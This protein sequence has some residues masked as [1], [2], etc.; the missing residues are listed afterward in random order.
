MQIGQVIRDKDLTDS[1][2]GRKLL[3]SLVPPALNVAL[4]AGDNAS[5]VEYFEEKAYGSV[6]NGDE[7][8][9]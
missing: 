6:E 1:V 8:F 7:L 4:C 3:E 5:A 9:F 2:K